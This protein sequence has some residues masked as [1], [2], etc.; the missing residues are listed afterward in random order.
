M[1][2]FRILPRTLHADRHGVTALEYA[3]VAGALSGLLVAAFT[4][5]GT[6][7]QAAL[8]AVAALIPGG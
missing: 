6:D 3:L 8:A 4:L 1:R 7:L 2:Y 5:L